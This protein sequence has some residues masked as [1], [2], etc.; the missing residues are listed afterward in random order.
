MNIM[1]ELVLTA[2]QSNELQDVTVTSE[3]AGEEPGV[4]MDIS[5][6]NIS[7]KTSEDEFQAIDKR[8]LIEKI[9]DILN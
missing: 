6:R 4:S 2:C 1:I 5:D 8:Q 9:K 3:Q 7:Y